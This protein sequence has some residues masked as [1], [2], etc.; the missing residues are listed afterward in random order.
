MTMYEIVTPMDSNKE[1][2]LGVYPTPEQAINA[3]YNNFVCEGKDEV[4]YIIRKLNDEDY[5]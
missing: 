1:L 4:K 5:M 2:V 3:I